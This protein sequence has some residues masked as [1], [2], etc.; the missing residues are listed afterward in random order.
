[1]GISLPQNAA[2]VRRG[3]GT[4]SWT[5]N[6]ELPDVFAAK[7]D[8]LAIL[9]EIGAPAERLMVMDD[10]PDYYHPGRSGTLCLGPKVKLARFGEIHPRVLQ[11]MDVKGPVAAFEV[12]L[13]AVPAPRKKATKARPVY[14][15]SDFQAVERDFA[16]V[17]DKSVTADSMI[18]AAQ[19]AD[20]KLIESV[21]IFDVFEGPSIGEDKKSV[22]LTVRLQPDDRTLTDKEIDAVGEKVVAAVKKSSGGELR[23]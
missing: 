14:N 7:A 17:V 15:V 8:A 13:G 3:A 11:M 23:G 22:A 10:A 19:G 9:A 5:G 6:V 18:R 16:F 21:G 2:G 20:K 12:F 4:R 1:M